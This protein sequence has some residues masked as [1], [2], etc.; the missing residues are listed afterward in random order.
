MPSALPFL[1]AVSRDFGFSIINQNFVVPGTCPSNALISP[2]LVIFGTL[3]VLTNSAL[4]TSDADTLVQYQINLATLNSSI[5]SISKRFSGWNDTS[6]AWPKAG[7][8]PTGPSHDEGPWHGKTPSEI[9]D[10]ISGEVFLT[11]VNQQNLPFSEPLQDVQVDG[12]LVTFK[13]LFPGKT[14]EMNGLT[15][16]AVTIGNGP[17]ASVDNVES[18][19]LFGPG[20]IEVQ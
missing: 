18:A 20:I 12:D 10:S 2:P 5:T 1:T 15:I 6:S 4:I 13:A 17:F 3:T 16:A 11:Y 14:H 8:Q 9:W 19:T 7:S